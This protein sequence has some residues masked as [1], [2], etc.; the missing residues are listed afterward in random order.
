[1]LSKIKRMFQ[2][3][4]Q[5]WTT[6]ICFEIIYRGIA[7]TILFPFLQYLL[8]CILTL[9]KKDYLSQENILVIIKNP[10]SILLLFFIII[11]LCLYIYL[12]ISALII[13]CEI[14]WHHNYISVWK[15]YKTSAFK[16]L[17]LLHPTRLP[18]FTLLFPIMLSF[19][20][21][22]SIYLKNIHIP[23][24]ILDFI[25]GNILYYSIFLITIILIHLLLYYYFFGFYFLFLKEKSFK[26]S[27]KES[28][29]LLKKKKL[30]TL[31][32]LFIYMLLF[33]IVITAVTIAIICVIAGYFRFFGKIE[34]AR[35]QFQ[36]YFIFFY[37]IWTIV[38]NA[39]LSILLCTII[40]TLYHQYQNDTQL[41]FQKATNIKKPLLYRIIIS[42]GTLILLFIFSETEMSETFFYYLPES[43]KMEIIAHRAGANLAPENSL[44]A[45]RG[46]INAKASMAEID[47]QQLKDGT[48]VVLHDT[49]FKRTSGIN[50]NVSETDYK[51]VKNLDI[52][53]YF[54]NKFIGEPVPTL[55]QMLLAAKDKIT[56]MIELKSSGHEKNMEKQVLELIEKYDMQ[57]QC[58][59]ASM[60]LDILKHIKDLNSEIYTVYIS[61]F[62]IS[63]QYD[64]KY[65]DAYSLETTSLS[66]SLVTQAHLQGK[67]VYAWTA[68]TETSVQKI[69]R[70]YADG[71]VTD[72]PQLIISFLEKTDI[73]SLS[74]VIT[75]FFFP[76]H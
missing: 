5:N 55:E 30:K 20:S 12:E 2:I 48:L 76:K 67:K 38:C 3:I 63:K 74:D 40:V 56:L 70:C 51:T 65:L 7:F 23:E 21:I 45:L 6:L 19:F 58:V 4:L 14:G 41:E 59:I 62:L 64:L 43:F 17:K 44:S 18:A 29:S 36:S 69:V 66:P 73:I 34:S 26:D 22:T 57:D 54:S 25:K 16:V 8:S 1:M 46:S 53:S 68:N 27:F 75:D 10:L 28:I 32:L 47:I 39:F 11:I 35:T 52:G 50:L 31:R 71:I 49:N 13:Y 60:N 61:I 72:N 33:L 15:L 24:F 9:S 37:K 42:V